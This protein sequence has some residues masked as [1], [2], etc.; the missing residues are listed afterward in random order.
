[1]LKMI[2]VGLGNFGRRWLKIVNNHPAWEYAAIATR[3]EQIRNSC[4]SECGLEPEDR[5]ASLRDALESG[6]QAD[7]VLVTTPHFRHTADVTLALEHGL[8]V[9]VEK[10]LAGDL[11]SCL[12]IRDAV[13]NSTATLMVGEN[14]RFDDGAVKMAEIV[15]SGVI[16]TP[17]FACMQ[18]FVGHTFPGGDWRNDYEYPVLIENATHQF[19]LVRYVTGTNADTVLCS[20]FGSERT[21]HWAKP[22]VAAIFQMDSGL[23]FSFSTSW[24]YPEF[25][26]PWEGEWRMHGTR[27]SVLWLKDTI[28]VEAGGGTERFDLP[29]MD[30]DYTLVRTFDEFTSSLQQERVS[31]VDIED[32]L[33][34]IGMVFGAIRSSESGR[35]V[36]IQELIR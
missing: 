7:A 20:A 4:G 23:R 13:Q 18:Y 9:L 3:N 27:G 19:D 8:H 10:P 32:N 31:S 33:Q 25:R 29:S 2:Q 16:G 24:S 11:E 36:P 14:Y 15:A 21:P 34:T 26:T 30:P 12:A 6:L 17:E 35:S 5:F 28:V 1:M 22:N